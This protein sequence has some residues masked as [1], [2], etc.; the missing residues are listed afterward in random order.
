MAVTGLGRLNVFEPR[1]TYQIVLEHIEPRGAGALQAAFEQLKKKLATEGLFD[2]ARKTPPPILPGKIAVISSVTGAVIHDILRVLSRR[3]SSGQVVIVPVKVQGEGAEAQIADALD[4][5]NRHGQADVVILARGGGSLEDLQAFNSETVARAIARSSLP[6]IS[7]IGH[8]TD[9][10]IAD[11]VADLRA[12]TPSAAA[13]LAVPVKAELM[14][15]C[16]QLHRSVLLGMERQRRA[17]WENAAALTRRLKSP[18][19]RIDDAR[20][21]NDDL[22][23]RLVGSCTLRLG[24]QRERVRWQVAQLLRTPFHQNRRHVKEQVDFYISKILYQLKIIV[25]KNRGK[26]HQAAGRIEALSPQSVLERGYSITRTLPEGCIVRQA[27]T[28][29]PGQ[30]LDITVAKGALNARVEPKA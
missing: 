4:L 9:F 24:L 5:L 2:P 20:L 17:A 14:E 15:R 12:P 18:Q 22:L 19:Q 11:F 21:K 7:A 6:V 3:F 25:E 27:D 23:R 28:I 10:T 29:R 16:R 1:G 13:E 8:E 30:L 26:L